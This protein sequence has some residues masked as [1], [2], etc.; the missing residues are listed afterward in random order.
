[1][2]YLCFAVTPRQQALT[3]EAM[4]DSSH[5]TDNCVHHCG[6]VLTCSLTALETTKRGMKTA[7]SAFRRRL[8][9]AFI[10][11]RSQK[12][13][14]HETTRG[15]LKASLFTLAVLSGSTDAVEWVAEFVTDSLKKDQEQ[16][17]QKLKVRI[18][19]R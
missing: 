15:D 6:A 14:Q 19:E 9:F 12:T 8:V 10:L 5:L 13:P 4:I 2:N 1:M 18:G 3:L 16:P 7:V 11:L 17:N